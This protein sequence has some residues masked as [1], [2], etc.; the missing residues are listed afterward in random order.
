MKYNLPDCWN[1]LDFPSTKA[2]WKATLNKGVNGYW[3]TR[4]KERAS[5]YPSLQYV[6]SEDYCPGKK[7]WLI[8][9]TREVRDVTRLKTKLKL[10]TGSYTLQVNRACFAPV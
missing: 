8:Q 1:L 7:H 9:H 10:V 3:A 5:L 2:K 4:M 6:N